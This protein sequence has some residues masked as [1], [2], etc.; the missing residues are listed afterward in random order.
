MLRG[1]GG[2]IPVQQWVVTEKSFLKSADA[3]L[4]LWVDYKSET[5]RE[6][7][8]QGTQFSNDA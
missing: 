8:I 1:G 2:S 5:G 4:R 6:Q 7:L 3:K